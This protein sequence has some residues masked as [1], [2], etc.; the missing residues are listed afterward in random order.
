MFFW[1]VHERKKRPNGVKKGVVCFCMICVYFFNQSWWVL[2]IFIMYLYTVYKQ[3][4]FEKRD[5]T[6]N[7]DLFKIPIWI[8]FVIFIPYEMSCNNLATIYDLAHVVSD[9]KGFKVGQRDHRPKLYI[10][11]LKVGFQR[12]SF[13]STF[14]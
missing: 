9:I 12:H 14:F 3:I 11:S 2:F 8:C 10:L 1:E 5:N 6:Q 13:V 4:C 7:I